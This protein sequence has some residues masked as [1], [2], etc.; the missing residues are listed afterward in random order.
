MGTSTGGMVHHG[1]RME[2]AGKRMRIVKNHH[3]TAEITIWKSAR[4]TERV[5]H[6]ST[7]QES[8]H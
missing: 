5:R 7:M 4:L 1:R 8:Q 6:R 2:S 3:Q